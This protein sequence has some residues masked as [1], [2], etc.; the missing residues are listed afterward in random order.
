MKYEYIENWN[1]SKLAIV[2]AIFIVVFGV[3]LFL[4]SK[5]EKLEKTQTAKRVGIIAFI[6]LIGIGLVARLTFALAPLAHAD[7]LTFFIPW[8]NTL[9]EKPLT[10]FYFLDGNVSSI[11]YFHDYTPLYMYVLSFIGFLAKTFNFSPDTM[12]YAQKLPSIL[13]DLIA[14]IFVFKIAKH[15]SGKDFYSYAIAL[16]YFLC[17][18]VIVDSAVWGQVDGITSMFFIIVFY[19]MVMDKDTFAIFF[20]IVGMCFKLQFIFVAPAIGIFYLFKWFK[21]KG[22]FKE[23]MFGLA[24]GI[25]FFIVVNLPFT[26]KIVFGGNIFFPLK[27]YFQ[28]VGNYIY[29]TLNAFNLYGAMDLN[30]IELE[31]TLLNSVINAAAVVVP[32]LLSVGY[33]AKKRDIQ[34]VPILAA[35]VIC[36]VFTFSFKMHERYM[37]GAIIALMILLA[38]KFDILLFISISLLS[39]TVLLNIG[40]IMIMPAQTFNYNDPRMVYGGILELIAFGVFMIYMVVTFFEKN[41]AKIDKT[42]NLAVE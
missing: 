28:Q 1:M 19:F 18:A 32:C 34:S 30:F 41:E 9:M 35:F 39:F 11:D 21:V 27:I 42:E 38:K 33:F 26:Y 37:F 6:A 24:Y 29:Y 8:T 17:P 25:L 36:F 22:S 2:G 23:A 16:F 40:G 12:V 20:S 15:F 4:I 14:T 3:V 10:D 31:N 5:F 13:C 7:V